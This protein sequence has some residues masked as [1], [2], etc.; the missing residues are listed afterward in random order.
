MG[1][2]CCLDE[3]GVCVVRLEP[4]LDI[5][6][7]HETTNHVTSAACW[8][9]RRSKSEQGECT[10]NSQ[11]ECWAVVGKEVERMQASMRITKTA[12]ALLSYSSTSLIHSQPG[13]YQR[14]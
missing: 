1:L 13:L 5:A 7:D 14:T 8:V 3:S 12:G 10:K 4:S 9:W 11:L 6:A 2:L